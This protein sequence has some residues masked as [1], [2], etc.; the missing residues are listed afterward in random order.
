LIFADLSLEAETEV[1]EATI[2]NESSIV[3]V[4]VPELAVYPVVPEYSALILREPAAKSL[5][6]KV[7]TPDE[8][9]APEPSKV[10]PL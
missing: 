7:A 2:L 10:E 9:T 4:A 8:P 1:C 3:S 5:V 6:T